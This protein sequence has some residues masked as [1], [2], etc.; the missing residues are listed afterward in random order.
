MVAVENLGENFQQ[1]REG[2]LQWGNPEQPVDTEEERIYDEIAAQLLQEVSLPLVAEA[3]NVTAVNTSPI[4]PAISGPSLPSI[5][6]P[7]VADTS[8]QDIQGRFA[9]LHIGTQSEQMTSGVVPPSNGATQ[10]R[11]GQGDDGS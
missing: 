10:P 5:S 7:P 6:L 11:N 4:S 2:M 9:V 1:M 3:Q 8:T